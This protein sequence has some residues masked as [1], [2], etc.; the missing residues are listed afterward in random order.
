MWFIK[1]IK[2]NNF[3]TSMSI[4]TLCNVLNALIPFLLLP[5]LSRYLSPEEY[6]VFS[7]YILLVNVVVPFTGLQISRSIVRNYIDQEAIDISLYISSCFVMATI[8]MLTTITII[9]SFSGFFSELFLFPQSWLW[10]PIIASYG[11]T[12]LAVSLG[13]LQMKDKP[14]LYGL[15]RI[16]H[17]LLLSLSTLY[18]VLYLNWNW[19]GAVLGHTLSMMAFILGAL[20]VFSF[21]GFIKLRV[22]YAYIIDALKY[23]L[24]LIPHVIGTVVITMIDRVFISHYVGM[25]AVGVYAAGYQISLILFIFITSFNQVWTPWLFPRIKDGS[26]ENKRKIVRIIYLFF[27]TLAVFG[28]LFSLASAPFIKIYLDES[29]LDS[30]KIIPWLLASFVFHGMYIVMGSFLYYSK[31]TGFLSIGTFIAALTNILLNFIL[32]PINGVVGAAQ[33]SIVSFLFAFVL[34]WYF[35]NK[36]IKMPWFSFYKINS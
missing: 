36:L 7:I 14:I 8:S 30:T 35:S 6:G 25:D 27:L 16:S 22:S 12:Y 34:T 2:N 13:L 26:D 21:T 5:I 18:L 4:Y 33:A 29:Y 31:N 9:A 17:S 10:A 3:F 32:V 28:F 23:G 20:L 11:Q 15:V 1:V 24:P 19:E